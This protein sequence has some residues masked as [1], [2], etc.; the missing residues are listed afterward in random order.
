MG[1][2]INLNNK[3]IIYQPNI[4]VIEGIK[5]FRTKEDALKTG[6]IVINKFELGI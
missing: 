6:Q 2:R 4:P 1:Y 5:T 3:T